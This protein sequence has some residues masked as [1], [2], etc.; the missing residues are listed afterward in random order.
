MRTM[1]LLSVRNRFQSV[2]LGDATLGCRF[3][4][5]EETVNRMGILHNLPPVLILNALRVN[6]NAVNRITEEARSRYS[7]LMM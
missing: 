1:Q 4:H 2:S 5:A 7:S 3:L 6:Q